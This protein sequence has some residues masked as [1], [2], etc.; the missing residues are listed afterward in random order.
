MSCHRNC[1]LFIGYRGIRDRTPRLFFRT[2]SSSPTLR[3]RASPERAHFALPFGGTT[4][5]CPSETGPVYLVA[6]LFGSEAAVCAFGSSAVI[7]DAVDF[8]SD[9]HGKPVLLGEFD[10]DFGSL[11]PLGDLIHRGDD[12]VDRLARAELLADMA[13]AAPLARARVDQI[14]DAGQAREGVTVPARCLAHLGHFPDCA[15]HHHGA[16]VFADT[17]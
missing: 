17:N 13:V 14:A 8:A 9:R 12:L 2:S 6:R 3:W 10:D 4:A 1:S 11:D 7:D 15:G 5:R 16:R